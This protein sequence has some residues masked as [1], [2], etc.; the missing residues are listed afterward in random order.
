MDDRRFDALARALAGGASRR[1]VLRLLGA[2]A[3]AP[4]AAG[5]AALAAAD[6]TCPPGFT[7]CQ[8]KNGTQGACVDLAADRDHCGACGSR[9]RSDL[10]AVECRG[11]VCVRADCPPGLAYCGAVDLCRDLASDPLHCGACQNACASG[12]CSGGV[13]V[14]G[15][16]AADQAVCDGVCTDTCCDNNNCGACG[17]VCPAGLTCFEGI[18]DCPS[19]LCCPE[20][21]I[22][23]G[24]TCVATCY[25]NAN[26]GAC[27]NACPAGQSCFE[28]VCGCPSGLCCA[29]AET[30]CGGEC[31]AT[32][33][34]NRNC[35]ACGNV[36][37]PGLTC[38]EGV[39]DC[40]S[41][42]CPPVTA[43][44]NTGAGPDSADPAI[45]S[46]GRWGV[47][48]ALAGAAAFLTAVRLRRP[49]ASGSD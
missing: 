12:V 15:S 17:V 45:P 43:L 48:A 5:R 37:P 34:D 9:C 20:G 28:G 26:C 32:C 1:R 16:C 3:F 49:G 10:V 47:S 33:C 29:E 31:V 44:P 13:C 25:D 14:G 36:C 40:P 46:P 4:L 6:G 27:G 22:L 19:G 39:C 18:C 11:G 21:E 41:G 24:E 42:H 7:F 2:A 38:F 30:I 35:G 8:K 23:C